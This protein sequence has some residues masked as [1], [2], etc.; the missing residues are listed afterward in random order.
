MDQVWF[1]CFYGAVGMPA[2][3]P[4]FPFESWEAAGIAWFRHRD[5]LLA[6]KFQTSGPFFGEYTFETAQAPWESAEEY[7]ERKRLEETSNA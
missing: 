4:E 2:G 3:A 7:A 6:T 5:G 1:L